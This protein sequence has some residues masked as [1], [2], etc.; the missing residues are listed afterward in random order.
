MSET[1]S[2]SFCVPAPP[3][4]PQELAGDLASIVSMLVAPG[5][6]PRIPVGSTCSPDLLATL[7]T[8]P[9][10]D[11]LLLDLSHC[12]HSCLWGPLATSA[13]CHPPDCG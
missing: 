7:P 8:C 13:R 11:P 5:W 1:R 10:G 6:C 4:C 3:L 12:P 9:L 2:G